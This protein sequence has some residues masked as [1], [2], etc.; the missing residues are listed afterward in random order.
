MLDSWAADGNGIYISILVAA[1]G[2]EGRVVRAAGWVLPRIQGS[3]LAFTRP[4]T[5]GGRRAAKRLGFVPI[6]RHTPIHERSGL[7]FESSTRGYRLARYDKRLQTLS[8]VLGLFSGTNLLFFFVLSI[9]SGPLAVHVWQLPVNVSSFAP[10]LMSTAATLGGLSM[11]F[12]FFTAQQRLSGIDQYGI[13]TIYRVRD[14]ATVLAPTIATLAAGIALLLFRSSM[15]VLSAAILVAHTFLLFAVIVLGLELLRNMDPVAVA[16]RFAREVR[17]KDAEEWGLVI[18]NVPEANRSRLSV[19]VRQYRTNFGLRDPLMPI[20]EILLAATEQRYGQILDVLAEQIA[21]AYG[22]KWFP[23][24]PDPGNWRLI[25]RSRRFPPFDRMIHAYRRRRS[26]LSRRVQLSMLI[27]HYMLRV[28]RNDRI[29]VT[30]DP[31]YRRQSASF[32]LSRL[33]VVLTRELSRSAIS[34]VELEFVLRRSIETIVRVTADFAHGGRFHLLRS[35]GRTEHLGALAVA[36]R[37]LRDNDFMDLAQ[38]AANSIAWLLDRAALDRSLLFAALTELPDNDALKEIITKARP[39]L[40]RWMIDD[41]PWIAGVPE[42]DPRFPGD[43]SGS[44]C[45]AFGC[46][47]AWSHGASAG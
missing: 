33:I 9:I 8:G 4:T 20:H 10:T 36:C 5:D 19:T 3:R 2:F 25:A 1:R 40:P 22:C 35:G 13:T 45:S 7:L 41:S 30:R 24:Y 47:W 44:D 18:A 39:V 15:A 16:R 37:A 31:L 23:Q 17:G 28:H 29:R 21:S 46:T 42:V 27:L 12:F 26:A 11:T 34:R 38:D 32:V 6:G 14:L 43:V